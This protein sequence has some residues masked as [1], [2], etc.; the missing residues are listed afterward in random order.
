MHI[1][2]TLL[3]SFNT[4]LCSGNLWIF[5]FTTT[6]LYNTIGTYRA[7]KIL[8]IFC[9]DIDYI[10][11][12]RRP[13]LGRYFWYYKGFD[14]KNYRTWFV[15]S[16][17]WKTVRISYLSHCVAVRMTSYICKGLS[18]CELCNRVW[19]CSNVNA[20]LIKWRYF[21]VASLFRSKELNFYCAI[22]LRSRHTLWL[23]M[24]RCA[25]V[26]WHQVLYY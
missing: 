11:V 13:S 4:P 7:S 14:Y 24:W 15:T 16:V 25:F 26:R 17:P 22:D 6:W 9:T 3:L 23:L 8:H 5:L 18:F 12:P 21:S 1:I 20:C 10:S 19:L 2:Y